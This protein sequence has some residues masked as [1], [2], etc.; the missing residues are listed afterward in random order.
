MSQDCLSKLA[1][2]AFDTIV[3]IESVNTSNP[4]I[5][6]VNNQPL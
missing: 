3:K 6:T 4:T 1:T 2:I 5:E